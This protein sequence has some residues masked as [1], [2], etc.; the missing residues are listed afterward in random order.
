[1][2]NVYDVIIGKFALKDIIEYKI[3]DDY[4]FYN[5]NEKLHISCTKNIKKNNHPSCLLH[6]IDLAFPKA[7]VS[8]FC[9][10]EIY[11]IN[12]DTRILTSYYT[13]S[14]YNQEEK[15][16]IDQLG[17]K[18]IEDW[19]RRL[20]KNNSLSDRKSVWNFAYNNYLSSL[21]ASSIEICYLHL[22]TVLESL[23]VDGNNELVYRVSLN[24]AMLI[25]K[26][27]TD[28]KRIFNIVKK[29]YNIRSK[30]THG[31][32][33]SMIK[34]LKNA[35]MFQNFFEFRSIVAEVLYEMYEKDKA[36]ILIKIEDSIFD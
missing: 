12:W 35:D 22:T 8:P 18:K 10:D 31:D 25:G 7:L 34:E 9:S 23:L 28:R 3:D 16:E 36:N 14:D 17:M 4:I 5:K 13:G 20:L 1:M 19:Y 6:S 33:N 30:T 11:S 2:N 21:C 27:K 29:A 15:I 24:T 32:V 26:D